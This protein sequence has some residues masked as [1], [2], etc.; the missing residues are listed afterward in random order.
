M[1]AGRA[2][3]AAAATAATAAPGRSASRSSR[4]C[5]RPVAGGLARLRA[6]ACWPPRASCCSRPPWRDALGRWLPRWVAEAVAVP[7]AAQL[8]CTPV[9]AALVRPGQPGGGRRQPARGARWSARRPCSGCSAGSSAWSGRPRVAVL[10]RL[11]RAGARPWIVAVARHGAGAAGGGRRLGDRRRCALALLTLLCARRRAGP[12]PPLL[13][14]GGPPAPACCLLL[15]AG[16]A[17]AAADAR[18]GRRAGWVLVGLRRGPGR[19]AGAQRRAAAARSSWTPDP[20]RPLVDRLPRPARR[21]RR[22]RCWCSPTS[23]PTTSTGCRA[24][25]TAAG[26]ARST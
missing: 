17:G 15:G 18:A 13:R 20:T 11:R 5:C 19:R 3:R 8:A 12:G 9:V 16:R 1:G 21:G 14:A 2:A 7:V 25:S 4:C 26:S 24:C 6:V 22:C 10:G 23:T